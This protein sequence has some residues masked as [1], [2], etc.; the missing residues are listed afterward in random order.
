MKYNKIRGKT[1]SECLMQI[2]SKFGTS[3][4]ILSTREVK[5]GGLLG[6][7]LMSKKVYEIDFMVEE[8][9]LAAAWKKGEKSDREE[10]SGK[11]AAVPLAPPR[12]ERSEGTRQVSPPFFER[13]T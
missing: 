2:R 8:Q 7:N 12:S 11:A 9:S 13:V 6:S 5:E 4:H 10:K 1:V 3:V